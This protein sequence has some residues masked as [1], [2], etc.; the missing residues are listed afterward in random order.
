MQRS[1]YTNYFADTVL[2]L[3]FNKNDLSFHLKD[4]LYL[5]MELI[6]YFNE[7]SARFS[8]STEPFEEFATVV[9][10]T[11][12]FDLDKTCLND[13]ARMIFEFDWQ[14]YT[15]ERNGVLVKF[16]DILE[17]GQ[18]TER[19]HIDFIR[20]H[21]EFKHHD[22]SKD[23][24]Y[25]LICTLRFRVKDFDTANYEWFVKYCETIVF[26]EHVKTERH[27]P[28]Y[29]RYVKDGE[30]SLKDVEETAVDR[31]A[32]HFQFGGNLEDYKPVWINNSD[33]NTIYYQIII[34]ANYDKLKALWDE[35]IKV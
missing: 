30:C 9:A 24:F 6:K 23:T 18:K 33:R 31:L 29:E 21:T 7:L 10:E 1:Y 25:I 22:H 26:R 20:L 5:K 2:K 11:A 27:H 17:I 35:F 4:Q 19:D 15:N 13:F 32:R 8:T 16:S 3:K 14:N 34:D 28:E 12:L